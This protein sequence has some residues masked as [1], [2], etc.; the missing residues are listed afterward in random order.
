[1]CSECEKMFQ[2][3]DNLELLRE[4]EKFEKGFSW[5]KQEAD[6]NTSQ[7]KGASVGFPLEKGGL[8][9]KEGFHP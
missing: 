1:M 9:K 2:L 6:K 7:K 4:L 5:K 3:K 8:M